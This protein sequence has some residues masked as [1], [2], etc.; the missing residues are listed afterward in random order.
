MSITFKLLKR[1]DPVI[2]DLY[3]KAYNLWREILNG[4]EGD[5]TKLAKDLGNKQLQFERIIQ[6]SNK[7]D[8]WDGQEIMV[9]SGLSFYLDQE[10]EE[11]E[12][13]A[14]SISE[15]FEMSYC[16][17]EVK[18]LAKRISKLFYLGL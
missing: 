11:N 12:R 7:Y 9:F 3:S 13:L 1:N 16:S 5:S 15:A 14:Q 8:R 18:G 4:Y 10:S 17:L 6:E 2:M